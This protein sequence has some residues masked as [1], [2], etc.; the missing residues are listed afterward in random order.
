MPVQ[1]REKEEEKHLASGKAPS[2]AQASV[3]AA[4]CKECLGALLSKRQLILRHL[5]R[6]AESASLRPLGGKCV[7]SAKL[8]AL[9][10]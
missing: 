7:R 6:A 3:P 10:F 1:R 8:S 5:F 9:L 2:P 4:Q